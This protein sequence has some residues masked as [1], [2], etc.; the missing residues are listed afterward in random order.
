MTLIDAPIR[1]SS[2]SLNCKIKKS[3]LTRVIVTRGWFGFFNGFVLKVYCPSIIFAQ[4]S[5]RPKPSSG[6]G[7]N[8][9]LSSERITLFMGS[10]KNSS[11]S[12]T[13]L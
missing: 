1:F 8:V 3:E 2:L 10:L 11:L 12:I 9:C 4:H 5:Q 6:S 13:G 7:F